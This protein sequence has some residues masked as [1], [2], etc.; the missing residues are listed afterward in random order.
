MTISSADLIRINIARRKAGRR[1][2]SILEMQT[3]IREKPADN[4]APDYD[5]LLGYEPGQQMGAGDVG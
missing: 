5:Y 4:G 1:V 3:A 2:L